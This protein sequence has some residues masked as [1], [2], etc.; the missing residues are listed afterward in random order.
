MVWFLYTEALY[1]TSRLYCRI[2]INIPNWLDHIFKWRSLLKNAIFSL[3]FDI[4]TILLPHFYFC[5]NK[6]KT[7]WKNVLKRT[8]GL[9][10]HYYEK[11]GFHILWISFLLWTLIVQVYTHTHNYTLNDVRNQVCK[12]MQTEEMS[13]SFLKDSGFFLMVAYPSS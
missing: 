2:A 8:I 1:K 5:L 10:F 7:V 11:N 6:T 4:P 12:I 9:E 13:A 3:L